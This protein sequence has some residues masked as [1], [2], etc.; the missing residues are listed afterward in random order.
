MGKEPS[1]YSPA[2][3]KVLDGESGQGATFL[4]WDDHRLE[5]IPESFPR[6]K[7]QEPP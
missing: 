5:P 1:E 4:S 2:S 6:E 7:I 3:T